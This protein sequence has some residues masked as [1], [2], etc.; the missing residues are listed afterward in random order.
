M[1]LYAQTVQT[2]S[3]SSVFAGL[4]LYPS[5]FVALTSAVKSLTSWPFTS[6]VLKALE[7]GLVMHSSCSLWSHTVNL[8]LAVRS[9][10]FLLVLSG[11]YSGSCSS[12][13]SI[14]LGFIPSQESVSWCSIE[15]IWASSS[16]LSSLQPSVSVIKMTDR[17][18]DMWRSPDLLVGLWQTAVLCAGNVYDF[19]PWT[20]Y[21]YDVTLYLVTCMSLHFYFCI[22][23]EFNSFLFKEDIVQFCLSSS[24]TNHPTS[25]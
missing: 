1:C 21:L 5:I 12:T 2:N 17:E 16:L 20:C 14:H 8:W 6:D 25:G 24:Y 4:G 19:P 18:T 3:S 13:L 15:T 22:S 23:V 9:L 11:F 7:T 10:F